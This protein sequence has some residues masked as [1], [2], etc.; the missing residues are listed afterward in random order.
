MRTSPK[1]TFW[2]RPVILSGGAWQA[3]ACLSGAPRGEVAVRPARA[4][5]NGKR[6]SGPN[7]QKSIIFFRRGEMCCPPTTAR[8]ALW[9]VGVFGGAPGDW[10]V[11]F[12]KFAASRARRLKR[13]FFGHGPIEGG[14]FSAGKLTG[15]L[16][17][18][19]LP[20]VP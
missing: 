7:L 3:A 13:C 19:M 12:Y 14:R 4:F 9:N 6:K 16:T 5:K 20:N 17:R 2:R 10:L 15:E 18:G 11:C 8:P 1:N